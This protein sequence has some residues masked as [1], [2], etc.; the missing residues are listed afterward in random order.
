MSHLRDAADAW[1][2]EKNIFQSKRGLVDGILQAYLKTEFAESGD[3]WRLLPKMRCGQIGKESNLFMK[4]ASATVFPSPSVGQASGMKLVV[5]IP[6]LNEEKTIAQVI[7]GVPRNLPGVDEVEVIVM[8]DGST[9][10][11]AEVAARAGA[12]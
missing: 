2:F 11:T 12:I 1:K 3:A 10:R 6:A 5:T 4:L 8:N 9:D 7:A